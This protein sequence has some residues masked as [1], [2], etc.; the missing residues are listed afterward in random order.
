[1]IG[2][3]GVQGPPGQGVAYDTQTDNVNDPNGQSERV[4][5]QTLSS[6]GDFSIV[7]RA[8]G[9]QGG[10]GTPATAWDCDLVAANPGS[11]AVVL[12]STGADGTSTYTQLDLQGVVSLAPGGVVGINCEEGEQQSGDSFTDV[13][14]TSTQISGFSVVPPS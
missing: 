13:H 12:D 10:F 2:P 8:V 1:L 3:Q 7:A 6:G 5:T 9:V 4:L 14:I 11:S